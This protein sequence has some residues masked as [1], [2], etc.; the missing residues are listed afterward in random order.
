[1]AYD[2][3]PSYISNILPEFNGAAS[4]KTL[5]HQIRDVLGIIESPYEMIFVDDGST[6]GSMDIMEEI[7]CLLGVRQ[8]RLKRL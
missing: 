5:Y 3:I 1:M 8:L 4:L 7:Y 6:V 2:R